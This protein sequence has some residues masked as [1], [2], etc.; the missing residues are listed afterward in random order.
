[1]TTA[2][3][4]VSSRNDPRPHFELR[5]DVAADL[6]FIGMVRDLAAHGARY[7]GCHDAD[8]AD[9]AARVENCAREQ[10]AWCGEDAIV[11]VT[12]RQTQAALEVVIGTPRGARTLSLVI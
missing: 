4:P 2:D 1:M 10:F 3:P 11:V 9:F 6:R 8:A 5:V 12:V 7:A